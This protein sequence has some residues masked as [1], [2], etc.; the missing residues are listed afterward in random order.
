MAADD[1][2]VLR[3]FPSHIEADLARS[4]LEAAGV[5]SALRTDDLGGLRP[6]MDLT[7]GVALMVR[8]EDRARAAEVLD[9]DVR[10]HA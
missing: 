5:E 10:R 2:V 4:V 8:S 9:T 3:V 6:H 1:I 7:R